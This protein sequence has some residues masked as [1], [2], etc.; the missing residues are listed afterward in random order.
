MLLLR[1]F[2][3]TQLITLQA[4]ALCLVLRSVKLIDGLGTTVMFN[5][6]L[7]LNIIDISFLL[8]TPGPSGNRVTEPPCE[9]L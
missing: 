4:S 8:R 9:H 6:Y 5:D 2:R 3:G 7:L 1:R